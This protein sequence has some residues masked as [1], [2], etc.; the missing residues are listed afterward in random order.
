MMTYTF[1]IT[2]DDLLEAGKTISRAAGKSFYTLKHK[3]LFMGINVLFWIPIGIAWA[4][5]NRVFGPLA[6]LAVVGSVLCM[7]VNAY[8]TKRLITHYSKQ[9]PLDGGPTIGEFTLAFDDNALTLSDP[10]MSTTI[11]WRNVLKMDHNKSFIFLYIDRNVALIIPKRD[12]EPEALMSELSQ[13]I[14]SGQAK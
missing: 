9:I 8:I 14:D 7:L 4:Y 6:S 3:L 1:K 2:R 13:R 5:T 11:K 10:V 12:V